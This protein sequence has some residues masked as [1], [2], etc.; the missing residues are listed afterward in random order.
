MENEDRALLVEIRDKQSELFVKIALLMQKQEHRDE[1]L[2][3]AFLN[4]EKLDSKFEKLNLRIQI[5]ERSETLNEKVRS[6]IWAGVSMLL[7][8]ALGI[9]SMAVDSHRMTID[10]E[11]KENAADI[12]R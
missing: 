9:V 10:G 2:S 4:I 1:D 5:L 3:R 8:A 7:I 11:S 6:A 12:R